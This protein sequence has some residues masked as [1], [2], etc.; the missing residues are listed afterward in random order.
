MDDF[1]VKQ[2]EAQAA[3]RNLICHQKP[4]QPGGMLARDHA[5]LTRGIVPGRPN[6]LAPAFAARATVATASPRPRRVLTKVVGG[7]TEDGVSL[8]YEACPAIQAVRIRRGM[9]I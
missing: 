3:T 8:D 1:P 5:D 7:K 9:V 6:V 4:A 2:T